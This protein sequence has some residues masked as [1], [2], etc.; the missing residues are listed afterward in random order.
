M[1]ES[2]HL[3][4]GV[5]VAWTSVRQRR[6]LEREDQLAEAAGLVRSVADGEGSLLLVEGVAGIGKTGVVRAVRDL[7]RDAGATTL[8]ARGSELE[9]QSPFGAVRGLL[10]APLARADPAERAALLSGAAAAAGALLDAQGAPVTEAPT[11]DLLHGLAWFVVNLADRGPLVLLV[12]DAHWLDSPSARFLSYLADRLEDAPILLVVALRPDEPGAPRALRRLALHPDATLLRPRPLS[13]EAVAALTSDALRSPPTAAFTT[14]CR[15]AT[16]GNPFAIHSLLV[17]LAADGARPDD[18]AAARLAERLPAE[19]GRAM[20]HRL[21]GLPEAARGLASAVAVLGDGS[22]LSVA[23]RLAGLE[24]A[25]AASVAELLVRVDILAPGPELGFSHPLARGAVYAGMPSGQRSELHREAARMLASA[26]APERLALHLLEVQPA[27]DPAVVD[28]L[29][30]AARTARTLGGRGAATAF[31]RR[32][33]AEPPAPEQRFATLVALGSAEAQAWDAAALGHLR[34][35]LELAP[36]PVRR[37]EIAMWLA[38]AHRAFSDYAG[39]AGIL[40]A[41]RDRLGDADADMAR[42]L[43]SELLHSAMQAPS[44]RAA[45]RE[46]PRPAAESLRGATRGERRLLMALAFEALTS[47]EPRD[48]GLRLARRALAGAPPLR[49][50]PPGST[51]ALFPIAGVIDAGAHL[52][53]MTVL[54]WMADEARRKGSLIGYVGAATLRAH[55]RRLAGDLDGAE[56]DAVSCWRLLRGSP[57]ALNAASALGVLVDV[58]VARGDL[59]GADAELQASD[60][61]RAPAD[62]L[63]L[64][65]LAAARLRLRLGQRRWE[66]ALEESDHLD[67]ACDAL[68]IGVSGAMER[69]PN[70]VLALTGLG[71]REEAVAEAAA[72]V[73]RARRF[74]AP[75]ALSAALRAQ[76]LALGGD[77]GLAA[78]AAAAAAAEGPDAPLYLSRALLDH[79]GALRRTGRHRSAREPL[80]RAL[81]LAVRCGAHALAEDARTELLAAGARPRRS[82]LSGVAALTAAERRV[83]RLAADGLTNPEIAQALYITRKTVEKHMGEVLRKLELP[84]RERIAAAFAGDPGRPPR[85]GVGA[86]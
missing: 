69:G 10:E 78:L 70:R 54:D 86:P 9:R 36:D 76:G 3:F 52:D 27:G 23:A 13:E 80:R 32:A 53:V 38:G 15:A 24:P 73:R 63:N 17:D 33:L 81:D 21:A 59:A 25:L 75:Y 19:V 83:A 45:V 11:F 82:A 68:G 61:A 14:A 79:G 66:E 48:R 22:A 34:E 71:R 84:S 55:A 6:L 64:L 67:A 35:A 18:D 62:Q 7:A 46:R 26:A 4:A 74:G 49:D 72:E 58:L 57:G 43:E 1:G 28:T 60:L 2:P 20:E 29:R 44:A 40:A 47:G 31:L 12:D 5:G 39:A 51:I 85:A 8:A 65:M 41:E 42:I 16:G 56:A 30:A 37:A 77:D 50:E